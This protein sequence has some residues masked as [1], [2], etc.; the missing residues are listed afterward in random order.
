MG[1]AYSI[2]REASGL[3]VTESL[4]NGK[5]E[6]WLYSYDGQHE[7]IGTY[8]TPSLESLNL[9]HRKLYFKGRRQGW[10]VT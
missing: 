3:F 6:T 4:P 9:Q 10:C 7:L 2:F 5:I 1:N 8:E